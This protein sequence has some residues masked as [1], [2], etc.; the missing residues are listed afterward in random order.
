MQKKMIDIDYN[1]LQ[2]E[3]LLNCQ[4]KEVEFKPSSIDWLP[5]INW[6]YVQR[7]I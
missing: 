2:M 4:P 1:Q 5:E 6:Y 3:F 7:L